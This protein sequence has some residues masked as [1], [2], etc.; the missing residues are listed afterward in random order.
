MALDELIKGDSSF[1]KIVIH[2]KR[3]IEDLLNPV[4]VNG[5]TLYL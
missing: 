4:F 5:I 3:K 1:Q 2:E